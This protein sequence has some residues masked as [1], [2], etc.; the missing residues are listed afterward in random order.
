V[1]SVGTSPFLTAE[2]EAAY[3]RALGVTHE[4][5]NFVQLQT[6]DVHPLEALAP[7]RRRAVRSEIN[8]GLRHGLRVLPALDG[9]QLEEWVAIY[10]TRYMEM[11]AVPYPMEFHRRAFEIAVPAG[12][13][14]FWGVADGDRLV[15]GVMFL[16]SRD[17]VDYFSSASL[18]EYRHL[19]PTTLL[20]NE[21]FS[22]FM[23]RGV[24]IFN[25][26]SSP[27]R[28][29]VYQYKARWGARDW[30]YFYLSTLLRP[31]TALLRT[32]VADVRRAY[33]LRFVLPFSVWP[34]ETAS[35]SPKQ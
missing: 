10:R 9:R 34:S 28:E 32:P 26:H 13:A 19:F 1:L 25:W 20:L 3:R 33:P 6:L 29:G 15:G 35:T 14:E 12:A 8:R 18:S 21:A 16:I 11:G 2:A 7:K 31:D 23:A 5:E 4:F 30:R 27:N 24:R 22:A 17:V